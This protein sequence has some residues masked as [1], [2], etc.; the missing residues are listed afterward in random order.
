M[1]YGAI[2]ATLVHLD[3]KITTHSYEYLRN[4]FEE[5]AGEPWVPPKLGR[6]FLKAKKACGDR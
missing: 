5:L 1:Y 3:E 6:L 4:A 2:S